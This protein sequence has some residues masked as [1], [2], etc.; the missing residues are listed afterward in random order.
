MGGFPHYGDVN[1]DYVMLKGAVTGVKK[2]CVTLRKSPGLN[3]RGLKEVQVIRLL[4][5]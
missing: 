3:I 2:R 5:T 4:H 1:E